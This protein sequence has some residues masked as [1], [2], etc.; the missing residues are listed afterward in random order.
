MAKASLSKLALPVPSV[1]STDLVVVP[2][3]PLNMLS[4]TWL[5]V[6]VFYNQESFGSTTALPGV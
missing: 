6:L 2:C 1:L 4:C 3:I 5:G